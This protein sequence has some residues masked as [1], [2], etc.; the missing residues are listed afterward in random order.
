[1]AEIEIFSD[2]LNTMRTYNEG[3]PVRTSAIT[4][5]YEAINPFRAAFS[6]FEINGRWSIIIE[7]N[8]SNGNYD[9]DGSSGNSVSV[10]TISDVVIIVTDHAG[11]EDTT[12]VTPLRTSSSTTLCNA[13]YLSTSHLLI[14]HLLYFT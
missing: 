1:M 4:R 13:P 3:S 5:P 9:D 2:R 7:Q 12:L 11:E 6:N 8:G 10:G 14:V